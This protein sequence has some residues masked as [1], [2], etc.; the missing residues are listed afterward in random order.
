MNQTYHHRRLHP[1]R[2]TL[3]LFT[4]LISLLFVVPALAEYLGPDRHTVELVRV[5]D[6]DNDVWTL[7]HV[8]TFD[9]Y[10]DVCLIIHTCDEHPSVDRQLALCG[11]IADTSGCDKAYRWE[12]QEVDL[13]EATI[14]KGYPIKVDSDT[15]LTNRRFY[16]LRKA[17][18]S[19]RNTH[20]RH[21]REELIL[22]RLQ[23]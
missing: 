4:A 19:D 21:K 12:E 11:W 17:E 1:R 13:P 7:T 3:L 20:L 10:L 5:R 14:T 9:P 6:P 15:R 22:N 2:Q 8:D 16:K 23:E 18:S